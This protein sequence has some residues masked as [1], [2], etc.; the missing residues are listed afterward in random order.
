MPDPADIYDLSRFDKN[1]KEK[2]IIK[3]KKNFILR[4]KIKFSK[5]FF[6]NL[7]PNPINNIIKL[8]YKYFNKFFSFINNFRIIWVAK[9]IAKNY[10]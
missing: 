9:N 10:N 2:V 1:L 8:F 6:N 4:E 5:E 3:L 7:S